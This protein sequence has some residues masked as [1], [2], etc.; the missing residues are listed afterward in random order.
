MFA[1]QVEY[2]PYLAQPVLLAQ[3]REHDLLLEAYSPFAHGKLLGD[4]LLTEIG[5]AH[6]KSAGS[7]RAALAARPAAGRHPAQGIEPRARRA[8]NLDV[9]DFE[10]SDDRARALSPAWKRG[11]RT[12]EPFV[13]PR[14]G[15]EPARVF[16]I[17]AQKKGLKR[18]GERCPM[19]RSACSTSPTPALIHLV[20]TPVAPTSTSRSRARR[21]IR[22]DGEL[23][24]RP[25]APRSLTPQD[26]EHAV[27]QMLADKDKLQEFAED[28]EVDFAYAIE[29]VG[30]FRVNAFRQRGSL[31]VCRA[32]LL[33]PHD[34]RAA[35]SAAG[36]PRP[37]RGGARHR[38]RDRHH[39]LGQVDDARRDDRP[40]ELEPRRVTS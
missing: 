34:R 11:L 28:R 38:P 7:G 13:S 9:F 17:R 3:A 16:V 31:I 1:N 4:P 20:P 27:F 21:F 32:T 36:H 37:C 24:P 30:R 26:T 23:L 2:H 10:L 25:G 8:Q 14:N 15:T 35:A 12:G 22:L 33:D 5:E 40:H 19:T 39:R 29:G 18:A 6:D